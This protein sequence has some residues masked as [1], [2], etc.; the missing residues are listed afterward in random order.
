MCSYLQENAEF[1]LQDK[2]RNN[3]IE[4]QKLRVQTKPTPKISSKNI[5]SC[6]ATFT[7]VVQVTFFNTL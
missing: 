2:W 5:L 3:I 6:Y 7:Q 4:K 1:T